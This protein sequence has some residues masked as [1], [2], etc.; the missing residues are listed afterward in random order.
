MD[1]TI[2][3]NMLRYIRLIVVYL[4]KTS[5]AFILRFIFANEMRDFCSLLCIRKTFN[6]DKIKMHLNFLCFV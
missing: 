4:I 5:K 6:K 3:Q 2:V 1:F